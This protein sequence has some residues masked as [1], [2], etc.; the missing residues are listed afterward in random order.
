MPNA[1]HDWRETLRSYLYQIVCLCYAFTY[2]EAVQRGADP[3]QQAPGPD[4]VSGAV[5]FSSPQAPSGS[6]R[7]SLPTSDS[8]QPAKKGKRMK[9]RNIHIFK[10]KLEQLHLRGS[11]KEKG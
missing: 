8:T 1:Q 5:S 4:L 11:T 6:Y 3:C 10:I 7:S 9:I 2:L